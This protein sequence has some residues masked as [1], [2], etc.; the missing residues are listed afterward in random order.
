MAKLTSLDIGK[1]FEPLVEWLA[2]K[3]PENHAKLMSITNLQ[4][5]LWWSMKSA[6]EDAQNLPEATEETKQ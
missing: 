4:E 2:E 6:A 3:L 1:R 5:A